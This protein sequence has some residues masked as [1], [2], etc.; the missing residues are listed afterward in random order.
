VVKNS[1]Y[2]VIPSGSASGSGLTSATINGY[3]NNQPIGTF[4]LREFAGFDDKGLSIYADTN[5]DGIFSD[6]DRIAAGTALPNKI[7]NLNGNFSYGSFDLGV[8]F[9][10]VAGNKVYDNTANA[11]FYK[12]RLSKGVNTTNEATKYPEE[13]INNSAPVSTRFLKDGAFFRL[14]NAV[15]GY[16]LNTSKLGI[17]KY[18]ST[19]RFSITGQNLFLITKY[20]GYDPDVN[21]DRSVNGVSSYGIDYLTYPKAKSVIFGL[22]IGL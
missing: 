15:L 16:N 21:T 13:S 4:Y 2:T 20:D 12:L 9:N 10:G 6:K 14:N 22:N 8:N 17:K 5:G 1:P 18:V 11:N 3:I 19:L 7:Y